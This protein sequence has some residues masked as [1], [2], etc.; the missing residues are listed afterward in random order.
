M[1]RQFRQFN[2]KPITLSVK[3]STTIIL[4]SPFIGVFIGALIGGTGGFII[5]TKTTQS[6]SP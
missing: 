1:F 6:G 4:A 5:A 3:P 2:N